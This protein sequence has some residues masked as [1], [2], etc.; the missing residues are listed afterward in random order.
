MYLPW[1]PKIRLSK[2][3][4]NLA[5]TGTIFCLGLAET[6]ANEKTRFRDMKNG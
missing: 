1:C 4:R 2:G 3:S 5:E 6:L